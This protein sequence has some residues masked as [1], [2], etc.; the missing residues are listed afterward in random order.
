MVRAPAV[1]VARI[2]A[3]AA[4]AANAKAR[5]SRILERCANIAVDLF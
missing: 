5:G 2:S 4:R 1:S 3:A